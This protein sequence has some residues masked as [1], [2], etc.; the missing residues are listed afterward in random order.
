M[1]VYE[2]MG[3]VGM[4]VL[5]PFFLWRAYGVHEESSHD[6]LEIAILCRIGTAWFAMIPVVIFFQ[7]H[8]DA[9]SSHSA[10][11]LRASDCYDCKSERG[12]IDSKKKKTTSTVGILQ[13]L[14]LL[15]S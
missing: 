8:I 4:A 9:T 14:R 12:A 1:C 7:G 13:S 11:E 5:R 15:T 3:F 10:F 6:A 2:N